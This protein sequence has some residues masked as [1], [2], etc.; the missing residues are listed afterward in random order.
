MLQKLQETWDLESVFP[1]GSQSKELAAFLDQIKNSIVSL[2]DTLRKLPAPESMEQ[3]KQLEDIITAWQEMRTDLGEAS[4]FVECLVAQNIHD[5]KAI[6][7]R[8]RVNQLSAGAKETATLVEEYILKFSDDLWKEFLKLPRIE[9]I[10]FNL[11]EKRKLG[12]SKLPPE[13]EILV[14]NLAIDGYQAWEQLYDVIVSRISIP[15]EKDGKEEKL[16][17]GQAFNKLVDSDSTVRKEMFK[18]WKDAWENSADL[19]AESLN[20]LSGFR[21]ALYRQRKWDNFL[22]EPVDICRMDEKT[23]DVMWQVVEQNRERLVPYLKRK[24]E[25]LGED[26]LS[27]YDWM[28]PLPGGKSKMSYDEGASFIVEH[29]RNFSPKMA[30]FAEVAFNNHWIEA[31]DRS[32]KRP[33]GFCTDLPKSKETRIFMTYDGGLSSVSTLA[34]ELGH[35]YHSYVVKDLPDL[36]SNYAMNVAETASTFAELIVKD[37]ALQNAKSDEERLALIDDKLTDSVSFFMDIFNR[38][39]FE[40]KFYEARKDGILSAEEISNLMEETQKFAYAG[41]LDDYFPQFWGAKLHFYISDVPFYNFPY[42]FGF[43]LSA[44]LFAR[45]KKE[46][47][48]FEDKYIDFLMDTGRMKVE[49]L[50]K[51]H[52]DVDLTQPEFW[53]SAVDVALGEV[54]EFLRL[55]DS[56]V[57]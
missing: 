31:E 40:K 30:D 49:D 11:D 54:D 51:Q 35:A 50:A 25:L 23:L 13:Q 24:K 1:G 5:Q 37:A 16:S 41:A 10:A 27:F 48:S 17:A 6:Q 22:K 3:A 12:A 38:F 53:Q 42:T 9:S 21:L 32:G 57:K 45:A 36:A 44:G 20:H 19:C 43:M 29:F 8:D 7:L 26:R 34:H 52:L 33:G 18:K 56:M 47:A 28:A 14:S 46:G 39:T 55:S 4:S 2:T 15:F